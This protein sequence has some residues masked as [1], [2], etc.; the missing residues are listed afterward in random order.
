MDPSKLSASLRIQLLKQGGAELNLSV[1]LTSPLVE[2]EIA[3]FKGL[4]FDG[5]STGRRVLF[6]TI[7]PQSLAEIAQHEKVAQVSLVEQMRPINKK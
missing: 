1:R 4:G 2:S 5:A 6:C 7:A 3:E